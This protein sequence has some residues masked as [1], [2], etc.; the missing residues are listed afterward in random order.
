MMPPFAALKKEAA[1]WLK[2]H[3]VDKWRLRTS[4]HV[5]AIQTPTHIRTIFEDDLRA[6]FVGRSPWEVSDA[7]VFRWR[8]A[9]AALRDLDG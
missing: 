6:F 1:E 9:V 7:D 3:P 5:V 2:A 4:M 8:A